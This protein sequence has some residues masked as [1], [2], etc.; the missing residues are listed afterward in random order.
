[1]FDVLNLLLDLAVKVLWATAILLLALVVLA[2]FRGED[3]RGLDGA[4]KLAL[5]R[6][7]AAC[8]RY[9]EVREQCATAGS[10]K[11]CA[12]IKMG[13]DAHWN[14]ICSGNVE[15]GPALPLPP[16]TEAL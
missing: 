11:T 6:Q 1:M 2:L 14:D 4:T 9:S 16:Q 3:A 13:D 10:F 7:A 15:G 5:C 8:K 12:R